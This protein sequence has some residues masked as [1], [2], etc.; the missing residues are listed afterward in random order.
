MY[1]IKPEYIDLYGADAT[2]E[3]ILNR[4]Q[5]ESFA[6]EWEKPVDE[7]IEQLAPYNFSSAVELM[8]DEI[9]EALHNDETERSEARFLWDYETR[10]QA[11]YGTAFEY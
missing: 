1:T 7:L 6:S 8:D 3:T 4:E 5:I 9:R 2:E 11:K 10:H